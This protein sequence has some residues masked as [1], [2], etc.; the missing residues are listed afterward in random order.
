MRELSPTIEDIHTL[1]ALNPLAGEQLKTIILS[2]L[3]TEMEQPR[4]LEEAPSTNGVVDP[5]LEVI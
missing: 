5:A 2:R 3:L 4:P 1:M